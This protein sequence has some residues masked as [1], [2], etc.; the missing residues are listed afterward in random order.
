MESASSNK[1]DEE[2]LSQTE[3]RLKSLRNQRIR[4]VVAIIL[5]IISPFY[6]GKPG[7]G[8]TFGFLMTLSIAV[9]IGLLIYNHMTKDQAE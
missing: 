8:G 5:F 6:P 4:T 2:A 7:A 3:Q 1:A 9:G